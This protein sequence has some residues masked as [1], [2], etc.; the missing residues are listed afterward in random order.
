MGEGILG[1]V[2]VETQVGSLVVLGDLEEEDTLVHQDKLAQVLAQEI[3]RVEPKSLCTVYDIHL[4]LGM[5]TFQMLLLLLQT[6]IFRY[7]SNTGF[8]VGAEGVD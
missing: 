1:L 3:D 2:V 8:S 5:G 7:H 6:S 4:F